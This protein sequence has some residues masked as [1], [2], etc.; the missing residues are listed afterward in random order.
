MRQ[1]I[2]TLLT[3][4]LLFY[5]AL[6]AQNIEKMNKSELREHVSIL[7]TKIDSIKN[8]NISLQESISKLSKNSSLVEQKNKANEIEIIRLNESILKNENERKRINLENENKIAKLN[9]TIL[10]LEDSITRV[11]SSS[12]VVSSSIA[13]NNN[14]FLNKYYFDQVPLPNNSYSLVL[15]KLIYGD[16]RISQRQEYYDND[17]NDKGGV[18][19]VPE[20]LDPNNFTYWGVKPNVNAIGKGFNDLVFANNSN[21]LDSKLPK[22]EVLK[23]KLFTLKYIDGTEESFL[24]NS[25]NTGS[26]DKNNERGILQIELAN[27]EVKEDGSNNTAKDMVWRFFIIGNECY[28]A[29][30]ANQLNRIGLMLQSA[31][32]LEYFSDGQ[33]QNNSYYGSSSYGGITSGNGIYLSR[34]KDAYMESSKYI[35]PQNLIYLF[36]LK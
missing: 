20:I 15:T 12:Y 36:K 8:E 16:V 29:L 4:Y 9:E 32:S 34:N 25:K 26:D 35:N 33:L 11:Y 17:N 23:N 30:N 22:I 21:Y 1:K 24:F 31:N 2:I 28:L 3:I 6:S 5:S 7:T 19:R 10:N 18:I 13:F 27:E 14:D